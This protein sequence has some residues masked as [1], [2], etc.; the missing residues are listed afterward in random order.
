MLLSANLIFFLILHVLLLEKNDYILLFCQ[1][2]KHEGLGKNRSPIH[3]VVESISYKQAASDNSSIVSTLADSIEKPPRSL[4][5][6]S[7][8]NFGILVS[9][10]II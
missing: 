1:N 9:L 10:S 8:D 2:D 5:A 3:F 4:P 7:F 6:S